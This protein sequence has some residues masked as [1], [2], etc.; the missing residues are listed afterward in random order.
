MR[1]MWASM[2]LFIPIMSPSPLQPLHISI[3][4]STSLPFPG[5]TACQPSG[6]RLDHRCCTDA[7]LRRV[8]EGAFFR[9]FLY[10]VILG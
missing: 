6:P 4:V 3:S 5:L 2:A 8:V 10:K 7:M 1:R 9:M